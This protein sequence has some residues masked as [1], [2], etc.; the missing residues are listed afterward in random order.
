MADVPLTEKRL[1]E[2]LDQLFTE[3]QF[4]TEKRFNELLEARL[5]P[6]ETRIGSLEDNMHLVHKQLKDIRGFQ[7]HEAHA[8]EFEISA[9]LEKYLRK[10]YPLLTVKKFPMNEMRDPYT[11]QRITDFDAAYLLSPY[12][13]ANYDNVKR[14]KEKGIIY[15]TRKNQNIENGRYIF[16]LAEAKHYIDIDKIKKKLWQ[17][18]RICAVF[19]LAND[20]VSDISTLEDTKLHPNFISTVQSHKFMAHV[21]E[22]RLFFGAA[23]WQKNILL[24]FQSD[25]EK[26]KRYCEE[27][28]TALNDRKIKLYHDIVQLEIRWYHTN[29]LPNPIDLS[30]ENITALKDVKGAMNYVDFIEPSGERYR[31]PTVHDPAGMTA[32]S[33]HG[34]KSQ[35]SKGHE[36]TL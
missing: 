36:G 34:G 17:F 35:T 14:L 18:D 31:I 27:F 1:L 33:L 6:I 8:I 21:S 12:K 20:V 24:R 26:R 30:D 10:V 16:V 5:H 29:Q 9:V 3:K 25:V 4:L 7:E 28:R 23:Y 32:L 15:K 22:Y 13:R 2:L 19:L 11:N